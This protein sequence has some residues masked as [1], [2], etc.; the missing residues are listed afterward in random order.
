MADGAQR[1]RAC[2]MVR[3]LRAPRCAMAG[4]R[5]GLAH[6]RR[7][8]RTGGCVVRASRRIAPHHV[9]L[10]PMPTP[11]SHY[12]PS[13][14]HGVRHTVRDT[15]SLLKYSLKLHTP[16]PREHIATA[17]GHAAL[18]HE[19]PDVLTWH[20]C[21]C[22]ASSVFEVAQIACGFAKGNLAVGLGLH[23][24]TSTNL[25]TTP[26]ATLPRPLLH[27]RASPYRQAI[28]NVLMLIAKLFTI[29]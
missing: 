28:F 1:R 20:S 24:V 2:R 9:A 11:P 16:P 15:M 5:V 10:Q 17:S 6:P 26:P 12:T 21:A 29:Q 25:R 18:L 7:N 3:C 23:F 14:A 13:H 8:D 19:M 22:A 4:G 27:P